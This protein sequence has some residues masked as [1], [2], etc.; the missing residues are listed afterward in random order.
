MQSYQSPRT[1]LARKLP[2][3]GRLTLDDYHH[4]NQQHQNCTDFQCARVLYRCLDDFKIQ[5]YHLF[6]LGRHTSFVKYI[7][8]YNPDVFMPQVHPKS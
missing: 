4:E 1:G 6:T 5:A 8:K 3:L 2:R 7:I